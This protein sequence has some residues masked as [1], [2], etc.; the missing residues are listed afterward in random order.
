MPEIFRQRLGHDRLVCIIDCFEIYME[1]PSRP[2]AN[3]QCWSSY[4]HHETLKVLISITPTGCI[5]FV[6]RAY[7][8]RASDKFVTED[9]GF[10]DKLQPGDVVMADRGFTMSSG[11]KLATGAILITPTF[12]RSFAIKP[13]QNR[14]NKDTC[15]VKN[16]R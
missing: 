2:L 9:S 11:I 1:H 16:P 3:S 15:F 14:K 5:S 13:Q 7:G 4:K 6:S 12:G 8:G 10:I